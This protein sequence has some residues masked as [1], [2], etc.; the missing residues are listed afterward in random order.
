[1]FNFLVRSFVLTLPAENSP[2]REISNT[3]ILQY[4]AH[5]QAARSSSFLIKTAG[6][7]IFSTLSNSCKLSNGPALSV[8]SPFS[9]IKNISWTIWFCLVWIFFK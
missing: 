6:L 2:G 5:L 7:L 4:R 8:F 1:M 9:V 3:R